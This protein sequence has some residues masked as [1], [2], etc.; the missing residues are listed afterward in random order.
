ME[1]VIGDGGWQGAPADAALSRHG[2]LPGRVS[3]IGVLT[4][5]SPE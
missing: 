2:W 4:V 5:I 1:N 3:D